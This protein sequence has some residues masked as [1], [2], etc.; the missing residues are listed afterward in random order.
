MSY[1]S[2]AKEGFECDFPGCNDAFDQTPGVKMAT[3]KN[4]KP[5][6]FCKAHAKRLTNEGVI[7]MTLKEM[8]GLQGPTKEELEKEKWK[9]EQLKRETNFI[10]RLKNLGKS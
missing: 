1:E 8:H 5:L 4:G 9:R 2:M 10:N 3:M 6:T 7:L